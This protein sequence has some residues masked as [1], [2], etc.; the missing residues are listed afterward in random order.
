MSHYNYMLSWNNYF[1]FIIMIFCPI[2]SGKSKRI[3]STCVIYSAP[4]SK[5]SHDIHLSISLVTRG[6][7][8]GVQKRHSHLIGTIL[9]G[10]NSWKAGCDCS[11]YENDTNQIR[12]EN[13][14]KVVFQH[15]EKNFFVTKV[16][17]VIDT[18]SHCDS[19]SR[20]YPLK[21]EYQ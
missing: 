11:P 2:F 4:F 21:I 6:C 16:A 17:C 15:L 12:D 19:K 10:A 8:H 13:V 9:I 3:W 18:V 7:H 14:L 20:W 1:L 5:L